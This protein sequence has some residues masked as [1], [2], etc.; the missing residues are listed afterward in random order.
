[1][2]KKIITLGVVVLLAVVAMTN[3]HLAQASATVTTVE[4]TCS[5]LHAE[6]TSTS[7]YVWLYAYSN[8][9]GAEYYVALPV[10]PDGS[11]AYTLNFPAA[12]AYSLMNYEVWGA[13][14]N[15]VAIG[16]P[17]YWDF[18]SYYNSD[19]NCQPAVPGPSAPSDF[20]LHTIICDTA[21]YGTPGGP[22]IP[23]D[24]ISAGQTWFVSPTPVA[25]GDG[26]SWTEIFVGGPN[27]AFIPSSCVQ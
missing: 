3:V 21:L 2:L 5:F 9:S 10:N 19:A 24:K 4:Q 20:V 6:G 15:T 14:S 17:G 7:P 27:D 18:E 25:A 22:V 16:D 23:D 11:F 12:P 1:M 8:D 13:P 26:S